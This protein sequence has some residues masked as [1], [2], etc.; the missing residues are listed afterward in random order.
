M[1]PQHVQAA[2]ITAVLCTG[3]EFPCALADV[4]DSG[5]RANASAYWGPTG[6]PCCRLFSTMLPRASPGTMLAVDSQGKFVYLWG[7]G[8]GTSKLGLPLWLDVQL[9]QTYLT[10]PDVW[11]FS[12]FNSG[13]CNAAA[14][15]AV[16]SAS[17]TVAIN[18][19]TPLPVMF[20]PCS[21]SAAT[22]GPVAAGPRDSYQPHCLGSVQV[23]CRRP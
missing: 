18:G 3:P 10:V 6:K 16:D 12:E 4:L 2:T 19:A 17:A 21:P 7:G 11:S 15:T 22:G 1:H 9:S 5:F 20:G 23:R 8:I 13:T 14:T